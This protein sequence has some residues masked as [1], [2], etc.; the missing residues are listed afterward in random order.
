MIFGDNVCLFT[1]KIRTHYMAALSLVTIF[2]YGPSLPLLR[3]TDEN[4]DRV[5]ANLNFISETEAST[6]SDF[7]DRVNDPEDRDPLKTPLEHFAFL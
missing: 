5:N 6:D 1:F 3:V 4:I 7:T 2:V